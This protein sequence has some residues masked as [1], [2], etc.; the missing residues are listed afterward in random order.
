MVLKLIA[1][2]ASLLAATPASAGNDLAFPLIER[3]KVA[4]GGDEFE[5]GLY[6]ANDKSV[7]N[8]VYAVY[9]DKFLIKI[10]VL[11]GAAA[12]VVPAGKFKIPPTL[13]GIQF[14][15]GGHQ[16][17]LMYFSLNTN[18]V[19]EIGSIG[20]NSA[21]IFQRPGKNGLLESVDEDRGK[22]TLT[23]Y[24]VESSRIRKVGSTKVTD[25]QTAILDNLCKKYN[26]LPVGE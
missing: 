24:K 18:E 8:F 21:C 23:R 1:L 20:T 6:D 15:Q 7:T 4:I 5:F 13:V 12:S 14:I 17:T 16:R 25:S 22:L 9:R 2:A 3:K 26:L 10:G 11:D 19:R